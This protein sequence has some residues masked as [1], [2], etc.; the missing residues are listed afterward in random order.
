MYKKIHGFMKYTGSKRS[1]APEILEHFPKEIDVMIEPFCGSASIT[2][3]MIENNWNVNKYIISDSNEHVVN[4]LKTCKINP[5]SLIENYEKF[6]DEFNLDKENQI[7]WRKRVY[8]EKRKQFN[9]EFNPCDLFCLIN[10]CVNGLIR[11]NSYGLFNTSCHFTRPG[12]NPK[13]IHKYIKENHNRLQ[14]VD[15]FHKSYNEYQFNSGFFFLDPPYLNSTSMYKD[16]FNHNQF[17]EWLKKC[18]NFIMTM[19]Q[20]L[21]IEW[22]AY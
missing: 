6:W 11:F 22:K 5:D 14:L 17:F 1:L 3:T 8:N 19:D 9:E 2:L 7:E 20:G 10:T 18:D 12:I 13:T 21:D 15:I 4:L 16:K